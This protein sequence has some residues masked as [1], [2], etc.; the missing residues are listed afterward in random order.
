M[1]TPSKHTEVRG[2]VKIYVGKSDRDDVVRCENNRLDT[3]RL[4]RL[5]IDRASNN[6]MKAI[7]DLNIFLTKA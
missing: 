7:T 5:H 2:V 6:R 4:Q 1:M 3:L